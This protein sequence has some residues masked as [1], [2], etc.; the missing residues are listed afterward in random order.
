[1]AT[2]NSLVS[3]M[4]KARFGWSFSMDGGVEVT[5]SPTPQPSYPSRALVQW[6]LISQGLARHLSQRSQVALVTTQIYYFPRSA[7]LVP[8]HLYS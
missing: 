5:I 1:M 7:S 6:H 3:L 4:D 2:E 8:V